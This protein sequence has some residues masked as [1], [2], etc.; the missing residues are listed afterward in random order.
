MK[1]KYTDQEVM[2]DKDLLRT[3]IV[4]KWKIFS[5]HTFLNPREKTRWKRSNKKRSFY[6]MRRRSERGAFILKII[7]GVFSMV[8]LVLLGIMA[9]SFHLF[10]TDLN[11]F[12][13]T[14]L[15]EQ[16]MSH[17]SGL[18]FILIFEL[19]PIMKLREHLTILDELDRLHKFAFGQE[20]LEES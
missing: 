5:D 9:Y 6:A 13:L 8:S 1:A 20:R 19:I 12:S 16:F 15:W 2:K 11:N 3:A 10:V 14:G 18:I 7:V 4:E 17:F